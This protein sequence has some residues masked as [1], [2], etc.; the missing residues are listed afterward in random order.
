MNCHNCGSDSTI[1]DHY[2]HFN[3]EMLIDYRASGIW[4]TYCPTCT[5][6]VKIE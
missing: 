1:V 5:T 2:T 3:P 6:V 4:V